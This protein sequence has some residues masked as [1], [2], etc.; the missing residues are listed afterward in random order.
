MGAMLTEDDLRKMPGYVE[1]VRKG[2]GELTCAIAILGWSHA[3]YKQMRRDPEFSE[4]MELALEMRYEG[5]VESLYRAANHP[6][7]PS[8]VAQQVILMSQHSDRGWKPPTQR[9]AI[10]SESKISIEAR[11]TRVAS[12]LALVDKLGVA[13]LQP[14]GEIDKALPAG[15][16]IDAE[17]VDDDV[18]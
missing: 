10:S 14:G 7:R 3:K 8:V 2:R 5:V 6:K 4:F 18:A 11:D 1:A 9:V 17:V 13:A 16:I 12:V 15:E